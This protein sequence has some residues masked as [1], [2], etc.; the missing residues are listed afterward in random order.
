VYGYLDSVGTAADPRTATVRPYVEARQLFELDCVLGAF[1]LSP[2][3]VVLDGE[4]SCFPMAV[5]HPDRFACVDAAQ[6]KPWSSEAGERNVWRFSGLKAWGLQND[7]GVNVW[8]WNDPIWQSKRHPGREWPFISLVHSDNYDAS[9]NWNALGYPAFLLDLAAEKRAGHW[10]WVDIGDAP[11]GEFMAIPRREAVPALANATCCQT[12]HENWRDEPRGTLNGYIEWHRPTRPF[13]RRQVET[14]I[15]PDLVDAPQRFE[16][17]LRIR[18]EGRPQN[19]QSVPPCPVRCGRVDVTPRRLQKFEVVTGRK[20][21]WRNVRVASGQVLQAGVI[22]P[23]AHG[24]LTVPEM[25]VDKDFLGNK[26]V[27]EPAAGRPAPRADRTRSVVINYFET[28]GDRKQFRNM[29]TEELSY[30]DYAARCTAPEMIKVVRTG[31]EFLPE[32]FANGRRDG[33]GY[34]MWGSAKWDDTFAF[35]GDG[36][37]RIEIDTAEAYFQNGAWPILEVSVGGNRERVYL[38]SPDPLTTVRW[39]DIPEGRHR[40]AIRS[41]NNTFHEPFK[42]GDQSPERDRGFTLRAVRFFHVPEKAGDRRTRSITVD[43]RAALVG[44][45]MPLRLRGTAW[46]DEGPSTPVSWSVGPAAAVTAGGIFTAAQPG[47]YRVAARAGGASDTIAVTVEGDAWIERFDDQWHDGWSL[48]PQDTDATLSA[49]W[50][51][52]DLRP[53]DTPALAVYEPGLL[54][55]D[56]TFTADMLADRR[57]FTPSPTRGVVFRYADRNN[58]YRFERTHVAGEDGQTAAGCRLVRVA[59]GTETELARTG[60]VP[61]PVVLTEAAWKAYPSHLIAGEGLAEPRTPQGVIERY[62]VRVLGRSITCTLNRTTVVTAEDAGP[63]QGT[64]GVWCAGGGSGVMVDNL[65]LRP[66]R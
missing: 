3:F 9:D 47:E 42:H 30:A 41:P 6:E 57:H 64:V 61:P 28:A 38:D 35:P 25:F 44:A 20:Y 22:E 63:R 14:A 54:W 52:L 2:D 59:G 45:G 66:L 51:R 53:G 26:L 56:Y 50:W 12:P 1:P 39:F 32:D 33:Q 21:L 23:D 40:V 18:E 10:W 11:D 19:G 36:R 65:E 4:S 34:S 62:E 7:R 60:T 43:P 46:S 55:S 17:A 13:V 48:E 49:R 27:I 15:P 29:Q 8:Q 16:M 58:H 5:H 37:Y 31:R 24:R